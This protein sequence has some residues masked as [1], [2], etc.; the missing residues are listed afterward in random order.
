MN[1][2]TQ[3]LASSIQRSIQ[4][5]LARGLQDP[6]IRGIIT[7]TKV[8]IT[9][10]G[11]QATVGISVLPAKHQRLTVHGLRSASR[12]IRREVGSMIRTRSM[13]QLEFVEDDS[14]KKQA[15]VLAELARIGQ[16]QAAQPPAADEP[17]L[18]DD[19]NAQA[20]TQ[21]HAHAQ[22]TGPGHDRDQGTHAL[23]PDRPGEESGD[24]GPSG[25]GQADA[26]A[27]PGSDGQPS[28]SNRDGQT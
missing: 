24:L 3:R 2:R 18:Q 26:L 23:G 28:A 11:T 14:F 19:S 21:A 8:Q 10:D 7:V 1:P 4:Q 13:P 6:R 20:H 9:P 5:V 25:P 16:E 17:Q 15:Q 27:R 22:D 12:H